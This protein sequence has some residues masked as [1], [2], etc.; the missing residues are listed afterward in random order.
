MS[1]TLTTIPENIEDD[2]FY[3]NNFKKLKA[4]NTDEYTAL[5]LQFKKHTNEYQRLSNIKKN[6]FMTKK[7]N[8]ANPDELKVFQEYCIIYTI[9]YK[10][11][12]LS[13][14]LLKKMNPQQKII[15]V[16]CPKKVYSIELKHFAA[17]VQI[18]DDIRRTRKMVKKVF[19]KVK[20]SKRKRGNQPKIL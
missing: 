13:V 19:K 17:Y 14:K 1:K 11:G 6:L 15:N 3:L 7:L 18:N 2:T 10:Q 12:N 9:M 16:R 4:T 8:D 20:I 5:L